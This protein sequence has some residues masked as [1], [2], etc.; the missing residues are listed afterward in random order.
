M[1]QSNYK[2]DYDD[3]TG[4]DCPKCQ[5]SM[6]ML[7]DYLSIEVNE[8]YTADDDDD[9][10]RPRSFRPLSII[11]RGIAHLT[12]QFF[13]NTVAPAAAKRAGD[14]RRIE[15]KETL[16]VFPNTLICSHCKFLIRDK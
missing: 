13:K 8:G 7:R 15:L 4:K 9:S 5:H 2:L 16:R 6:V 1:S 3:S 14:K 10:F 11:V 12:N